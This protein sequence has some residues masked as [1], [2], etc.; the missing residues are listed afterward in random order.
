M[1]VLCLARRI[2]E[3]GGDLGEAGELVYTCLVL[4]RHNFILL[5][6]S[7]PGSNPGSCGTRL[8]PGPWPERNQRER[9]LDS[10][11]PGHRDWTLY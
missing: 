6:C 2:F 9:S 4:H 5:I 3:P 11:T 8:L 7:Q 1:Q 10:K